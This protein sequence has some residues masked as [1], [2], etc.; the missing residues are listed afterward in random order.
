[1]RPRTFLGL[2]FASFAHLGHP[3][4]LG[5][6]LFP[7]LADQEPCSGFLL[8]IHSAFW[9]LKHPSVLGSREFSSAHSSIRSGRSVASDWQEQTLCPLQT[10]Q[11]VPE[12]VVRF[13]TLACQICGFPHSSQDLPHRH[14]A[15][16]LEPGCTVSGAMSPFDSWSHW[17]AK[18]GRSCARVPQPPLM[19][20]LPTQH[21]KCQFTQWT[22]L[23]E[24]QLHT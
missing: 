14:V 18:S 13:P 8:H 23:E 11:L 22:A 5:F 12:A 10:G 16:Y 1:M 6:A 7:I 4:A 9:L 3:V 19:S 24:L 20:L 2:H 15:M 21:A 17:S